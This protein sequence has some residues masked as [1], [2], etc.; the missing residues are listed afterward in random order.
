M[1]DIATT[2]WAARRARR[3]QEIGELEEDFDLSRYPAD[4]L[5]AWPGLKV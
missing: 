5:A 1:S 3:L 2:G 4:V